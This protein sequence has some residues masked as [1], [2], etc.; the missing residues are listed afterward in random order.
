M[1][2]LIIMATR[3]SSSGKFVKITIVVVLILLAVGAAGYFYTNNRKLQKQNQQ[4]NSTLKEA[5]KSEPDKLKA[6]VG[7]L[8]EVPA[9]ESPTI[10]TVEDATKLKD[11][12][13]FADAQNGDKVLMFP[14]AKKAFLYRPS[15]NKVINIVPINIGSDGQQ[16]PAPTAGTGQ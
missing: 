6:Q 12:A 11:Q 9:D 10:A 13:F 3:E 15:T 1:I 14:K 7:Q 2:I 16:S 8:V 4:L 5:A